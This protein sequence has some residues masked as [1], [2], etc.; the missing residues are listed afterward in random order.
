MFP[1]PTK[2]P[3][4]NIVENVW[5]MLVER[6]YGQGRQYEKMLRSSKNLLIRY[7][8]L[9]AKKIFKNFMTQWQTVC[10]N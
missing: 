2:S 3:G 5:A 7:G 4:L 10:L 1:W 6:V 9:F 8:I